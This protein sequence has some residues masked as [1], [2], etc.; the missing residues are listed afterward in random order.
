MCGIWKLFR[1]ITGRMAVGGFDDLIRLLVSVTLLLI[2]I[3][4]WYS[5]VWLEAIT[6]TFFSIK[7]CSCYRDS[8]AAAFNVEDT[9]TWR[10]KA[11][12]SAFEVALTWSVF[13][14]NKFKVQVQPQ[15]KL[16]LLLMLLLQPFHHVSGTKVG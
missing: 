12:T 4:S 14:L 11:D 7:R 9:R 15:N 2:I 5:I 1:A 16:M 13:C 8:R 10:V 3:I 6:P